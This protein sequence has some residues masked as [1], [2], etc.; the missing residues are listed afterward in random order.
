[1]N[2]PAEPTIIIGGERYSLALNRGSLRPG[3][4]PV[5]NMGVC[6]GKRDLRHES[7][8]RN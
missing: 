3:G 2:C 4:V 1:V 8:Q 6:E 7:Q 5:V